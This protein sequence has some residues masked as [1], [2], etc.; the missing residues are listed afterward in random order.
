M[1]NITK[2]TEIADR[3]LLREYNSSPIF[4]QYIAAFVGEMDLLFEQIERVYLG[5]FIEVAVGRQLDIIG[6]ILNENRNINLPYQFFGFTDNGVSPANVAPLSDEADTEDGGLFRD[7]VQTG[8]ENFTLGDREYRQLLLA[9]AYLSTQETCSYDIA[10]HAMALLIGRV[11]KKF[12]L[13]SPADRQV[14]LTVE[15]ADIDLSG[16][17]L[18]SYFSQYLVPLGTSFSITRI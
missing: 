12:E 15:A 2:G 17:A 4:K 16:V 10:Y 14:E 9:K 5:R 3:L 7:E 18:L 13:D 1:V 11:P 8:T 6:I